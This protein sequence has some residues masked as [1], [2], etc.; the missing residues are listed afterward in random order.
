MKTLKAWARP[1][2]G[3]RLVARVSLGAGLEHLPVPATPQRPP[4]LSK[5]HLQIADES[6]LRG[7]SAGAIYN[8]QVLFLSL[9][10]DVVSTQVNKDLFPL[11][12]SVA[13]SA[14][15]DGQAVHGYEQHESV[16][17]DEHR[18]LYIQ[19]KA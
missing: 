2:F 4:C 18:F 3:P 13:R 6:E 5:E 9:T 10:P 12:A 15:W 11:L 7:E 14:E 16:L 1:V 8:F 19:F 17:P